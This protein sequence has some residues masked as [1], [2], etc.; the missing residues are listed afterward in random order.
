MAGSVQTISAVF[1]GSSI[2]Y[3]NSKDQKI[4]IQLGGPSPTDLLLMSL[5]GCS[6]LTMRALLERDGFKLDKL[7]LKV[8]GTKSESRPRKFTEIDITYHMD[9]KELT[10]KE[11]KKYLVMTERACPVAQSLSAIIRASYVLNE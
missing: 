9:C 8:A 5:A 2:S 3:E 11:A 4:E 1:S 10:D 7:E 6:G